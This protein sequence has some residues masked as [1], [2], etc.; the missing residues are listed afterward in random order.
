MEY[1]LNYIRLLTDNYNA[2]WDFYVNKLGMKPRLGRE[3]GVYEEFLIQGAVLSLYKREYMG[4]A[5]N[6]SKLGKFPSKPQDTVVVI[7]QVANVD[8]AYKELKEKGV[9]FITTP[10]DRK[11]WVIRTAHLRDPDGNL[12]E[13]NEPL[14]KQ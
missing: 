4:N 14:K 3:N 6:K 7:L 8:N 9:E 13:L 12:I 1:N 10:E 5:L 11:E 2:V